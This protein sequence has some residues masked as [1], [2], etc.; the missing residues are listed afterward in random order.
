M[1]RSTDLESRG[2]PSFR[3]KKRDRQT[4]R[5]GQFIRCSALT[6]ERTGHVIRLRTTET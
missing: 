4:D 5:H 1:C 6:L 2:L 3:E